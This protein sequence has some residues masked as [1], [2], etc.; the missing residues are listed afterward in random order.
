MKDIISKAEAEKISR[1]Y[2]NLDAEYK[3]YN[4]NLYPGYNDGSYTWHI[5]FTKG[6]MMNV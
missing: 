3:L 4:S 1:E 5:Y 2:F 6:K